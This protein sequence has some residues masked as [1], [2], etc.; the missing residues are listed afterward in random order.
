MA[1]KNLQFHIE[2]SV[3]FAKI[4]KKFKTT[5]KFIIELHYRKRH[6]KLRKPLDR[7]SHF[8]YFFVLFVLLLWK[9]DSVA[10]VAYLTY[11]QSSNIFV[12]IV[13]VVNV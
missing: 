2:I 11:N 6:N 4:K 12:K 5:F 8:I 3:D 10:I 9:I 7:I 13:Y 1:L